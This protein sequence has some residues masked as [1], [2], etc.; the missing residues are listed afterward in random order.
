MKLVLGLNSR[1][2]KKVGKSESKNIILINKKV[3]WELKL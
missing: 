1:K 2:N 3:E